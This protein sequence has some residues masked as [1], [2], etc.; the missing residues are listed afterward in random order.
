MLQDGRT[1]VHC[2]PCGR[3][4]KPT[5]SHCQ[6]CGRCKLPTHSCSAKEQGQEKG[7]QGQERPAKRK[8]FGKAKNMSIAYKKK[9]KKK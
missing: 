6:G 1:Y 4:V 2:S 5:Y 8:K 3:C 7:A 9:F